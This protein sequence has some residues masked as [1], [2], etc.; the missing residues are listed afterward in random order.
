MAFAD[1]FAHITNRQ[2]GD[3]V[4]SD[5]RDEIYQGIKEPWPTWREIRQLAKERL[6]AT[7]PASSDFAEPDVKNYVDIDLN[8][9]L[10][11][12][13]SIERM[14]K[15][16]IHEYGILF[17][18][19]ETNVIEEIIDYIAKNVTPL[20]RPQGSNPFYLTMSWD[21]GEEVPPSTIKVSN[22]N[23]W[24]IRRAPK[25]HRVYR[26]EPGCGFHKCPID[27]VQL[28][29]FK[30]NTEFETPLDNESYFATFIDENEALILHFVQNDEGDMFKYI[31]N[32]LGVYLDK[33]VTTSLPE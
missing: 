24:S 25:I 23:D 3:L 13:F 17:E 20:S 12:S 5:D 11:R 9:Y 19:A 21:L 27:Q 4:D 33:E 1:K 32:R 10:E 15:K 8:F 31:H 6:H 29:K 22:F 28:G 26:A 16:H 18:R 14:L 30:W 7:E 2:L